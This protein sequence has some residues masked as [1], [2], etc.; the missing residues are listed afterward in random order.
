[1]ICDEKKCTGC[2]ACYNICPKNAINMVEDI[3]GNIFP[4]VD[5]EK[6]IKCNLCKKVCPQLKEMNSSSSIPKN[7][8]AM[9]SKNKET[10]REAA[11]G[12]IASILYKYIVNQNG[13]GYGVNNHF[14]H[15]KITFSRIETEDD[16]KEITGSKYVH[17]YIEDIHFLLL[18]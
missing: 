13:I 7:T 11:S 2:Y 17:A 10:R 4:K 3:Y 16:I 12:G 15:G 1:M 9:Y 14:S 5:E 6:C 8:Y 18:L